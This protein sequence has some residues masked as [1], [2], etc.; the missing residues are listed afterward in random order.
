MKTEGSLL[1]N[2][3]LSS[4]DQVHPGSDVSAEVSPTGDNKA[5]SSSRKR[6][7]GRD[8]D[9]ETPNKKNRRGKVNK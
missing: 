7:A 3:L 2:H 8:T 9:D 5:Q 1:E 4:P 6:A